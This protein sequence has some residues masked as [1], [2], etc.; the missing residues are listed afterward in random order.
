MTFEDME[1]RLERCK[2]T[3]EAAE[4]MREYYNC[5][6]THTKVKTWVYKPLPLGV[7]LSPLDTNPPALQLECEAFYDV[8]CAECKKAKQAPYE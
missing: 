8:A 2:N 3:Q 7:G 6:D 4:L 1:M 5:P